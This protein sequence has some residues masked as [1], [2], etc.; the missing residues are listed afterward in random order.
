VEDDFEDDGVLEGE[1]IRTKWAF[2]GASTLKEAAT[3][4]RT[5]ADHLES[6]EADGWQLDSPIEDDYGFMY[7]QRAVV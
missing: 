7:K 2:D 1:T 3:K 5:Y 6:L 4:L